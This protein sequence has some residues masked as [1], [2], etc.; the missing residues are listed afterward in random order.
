MNL[1]ELADLSMLLFGDCCSDLRTFADDYSDVCRLRYLF[2]I[3]WKSNFPFS[4]LDPLRWWPG[5]RLVLKETS[6]L[7]LE[8]LILDLLKLLFA[9]GIYLFLFS[10]D[11][12]G[13]M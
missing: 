11:L 7:V 5:G 8:V 4:W 13:C 6:C 3:A 1:D 2:F 12:V 10:E 9:S